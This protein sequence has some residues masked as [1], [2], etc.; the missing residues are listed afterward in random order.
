MK[1]NQMLIDKLNQLLVDY[2]GYASDVIYYTLR[3]LDRNS[4][5][6]SDVI[7]SDVIV[8]I[9]SDYITEEDEVMLGP[10]NLAVKMEEQGW[11]FK[12]IKPLLIK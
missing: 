4:I 11:L 9:I 5:L 8:D 7:Y 6:D 12:Q 3:Q 2:E 10:I 1:T